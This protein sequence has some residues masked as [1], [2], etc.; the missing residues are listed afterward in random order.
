MPTW[1]GFSLAV[2][3]GWFLY[4]IGWELVAENYDLGYVI[5]VFG[6]FISM[7]TLFYAITGGV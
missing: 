3:M 7:A 6:V 4:Q 2:L 1:L 5:G